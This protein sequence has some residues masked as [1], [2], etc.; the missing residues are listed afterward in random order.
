MPFRDSRFNPRHRQ[1]GAVAVLAAVTIVA[2]LIS[3]L[4]VIEVGRVYYAERGLQKMA[5]LAALDAARLVSGCGDPATQA[6]LDASVAASLARNGDPA[7]LTSTAVEVG[8]VETNVSS[9]RELSVTDMEDARAV[10]V[11]LKRPMPTLLTPLLTAAGGTMTASATATQEALGSLSVGSGLLS[12]STAESE[13]LNPLLSGLLGGGVN[14]TALDYSGL[15]GVNVSLEQ[16]ATAIGVDVQ[17]L[18]D[19]LALSTQTPVLSETINGLAGALGD[20]ASGTVTGLLTQLAGSA[21]NQDVPLGTILDPIT[22]VAA[23]VPFVNLLDLIIALGQAAQAD[24]GGVTPIDLPA[25]IPVP[26]VLTVAAFVKILEPPKLSGLGRPGQTQA[27]TAQIRIMVRIEAGNI[28]TGLQGSIEDLANGLLGAVTGLVGIPEPTVSILPPPLN[29]G[30]DVDVA[31]ATAYLDALQC[32]RADLNNG[33]PIAELS[34]APAIAD[35]TVGRFVGSASSAPALTPTDIWPVATVG[36]DATQA[37]LGVKIGSSCVGVPI[38]LGSTNVELNLGMTSVDVGAG[39]R[40]P[41]PQDVTQFDRIEDLPDTAP[42]AWLAEGVPPDAPVSANP[43]TVGS[44]VGVDLDLQLTSTQTGTGL[45]GLLGGIVGS[46]VN[47]VALL[48][49]SLIGFVN[50]LA[51]ALINP[52]LQL[53]GIDL[54]SA[55][56]TMQVV[57]VDQPRIVTTEIPAAAAP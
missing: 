6:A 40:V 24:D 54:G 39:G 2:L 45:I 48:L 38:N 37:C 33:E 44:S 16:L 31:K 8:T 27:S 10:R 19:P 11:T 53:L 55:T 22:D 26:G 34:A 3:S 1:R 50:T 30:I 32:P 51:N 21:S 41:L 29:I 23:D 9:L 25:S 49:D 36:I 57:T 18:S 12:I 4:L 43:Q 15:A 47:G 13:L 56:V 46:L 5:S 7:I 35:V 20:T 14:L 28:L 52:L 17:D 42:P